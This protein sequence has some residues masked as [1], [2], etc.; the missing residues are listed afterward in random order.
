M[1]ASSALLSERA[2]RFNL[3]ATCSAGLRHDTDARVKYLVRSACSSDY[4]YCY[5]LTRRNMFA[6]FCRHWGGWVPAEFRKSFNPDNVSMVIMNGRRVGYMSVRRDDQGI[7][8]ENIQLSP[9]LHGKGVG[10][11]LLGRLLS[12]HEEELVRLTTFRDNPARSLYE[13]LGFV[14]T[15]RDGETLRMAR[16]PDKASA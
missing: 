13:R 5:R 7:Y 15:E 6:L 8:V 3:S 9:S 2:P 12:L 4:K 10:T 1:I 16:F 11:E 14:V